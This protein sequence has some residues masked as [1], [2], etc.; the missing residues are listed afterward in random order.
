M[1]LTLYFI[2][3]LVIF[4]D[5][6]ISWDEVNERHSGFVTLNEIYKILN[7]NILEGY[8]DLSNYIYREY[9][10]LFNLPLAFIEDFIKIKDYAFLKKTKPNKK[11]W[12]AL[13]IYK[14][15]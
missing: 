8:P 15:I 7:L 3:G 13:L 5:Y 1:I 4:S 2:T 12:G 9:G 14:K 6:G 11:N 10:V